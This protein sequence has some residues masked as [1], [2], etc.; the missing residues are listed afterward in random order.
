MR[1]IKIDDRRGEYADSTIVLVVLCHCGDVP[2]GNGCKSLGK[3]Q[4]GV[5]MFQ[6]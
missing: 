5:I 3:F 2:N 4:Q 1:M 6:L